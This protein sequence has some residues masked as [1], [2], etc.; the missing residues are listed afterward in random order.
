[1]EKKQ[2]HSL[3]W[4]PLGTRFNKELQVADFLRQEGIEYYLPMTYELQETDD[5]EHRCDHVLV[6]AIH[7]LL[8]IRHEYN[9]HWCRK[10]VHSSFIPIYFFK[11]E[12]ESDEYCTIS[13]K[14]MQNFIRATDP[15]I[16]GTRFIDSEKLKNKKGMPVRI[17]KKGPLFGITG[18]FIRYGGRH[19]IAIEMNNSTALLKVSYTWCEEIHETQ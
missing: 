8:F 7:N 19:Y 12:R 18:K 9:K 6:P 3:V 11:R 2:K 10:F 5:K 14:E 15:S 4:I 17:V 13:D 1:M 16:Q